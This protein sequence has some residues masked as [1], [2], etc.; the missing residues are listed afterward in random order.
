MR[1]PRPVRKGSLRGAPAPTRQVEI[2][3]LD[4]S[5]LQEAARGTRGTPNDAVLALV[6]DGLRRCLPEAGPETRAVRAMVPVDMR[7]PGEI[8]RVGNR[9]GAWLVDLPLFRGSMKARIAAVRE[10]T[11]RA[12]R[13]G[14]ADAVGLLGRACDWLPPAIP[15]SLIALSGRLRTFNLTVTHVRGPDE[16]LRFAGAELEQIVAL[17]PVFAQQRC[18]IAAFRSG[19]QIQLSI[20]G[21]WPEARVH[22]QVSASIAAAYAEL[23][24]RSSRTKRGTRVDSERAAF[25]RAG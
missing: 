20:V 19:G 14:Q 16:P 8:T 17:A 9:L 24:E 15:A 11:V 21:A 6:A 3:T 4:E 5:V 23:A 25:D 1:I 7:A 22:Q 12:R 13:R 10:A 18:A 2:L